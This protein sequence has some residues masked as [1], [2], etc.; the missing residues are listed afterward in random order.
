MIAE[1]IY[2]T[3]EHE[4]LRDQVARFLAREVEPHAVAWEEQGFVPR[5]VLRRIPFNAH[6]IFRAYP[7]LDHTPTWAPSHAAP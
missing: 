7:A 4:L 2:T 1:S 6:D 5:E 3:P